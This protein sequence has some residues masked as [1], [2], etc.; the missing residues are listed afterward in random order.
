LPALTEAPANRGD[1]HILHHLEEPAGC[2]EE[3]E[4]EA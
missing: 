1:E 4:T 3:K 2:L